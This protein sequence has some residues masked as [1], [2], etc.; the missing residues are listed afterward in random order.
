MIVAYVN[1]E[2]TKGRARRSV[3]VFPMGQ[4]PRVGDMV[5]LPGERYAQ[6]VHE[7]KW[8]PPSTNDGAWK[9][10]V[11]VGDFPRRRGAK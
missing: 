1:V 3:A 10:F 4:P 11:H 2:F 6:F 7:V 8:C 5:S 9:V